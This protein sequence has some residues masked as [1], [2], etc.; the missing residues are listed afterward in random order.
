MTRTEEINLTFQA[1]HGTSG[2]HTM[3][4]IHM[5]RGNKSAA[6]RERLAGV[7]MFDRVLQGRKAEANHVALG[8]IV[9]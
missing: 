4:L 3:F 7:V 8:E 1:F 9:R 2:Y 6:N 5:L